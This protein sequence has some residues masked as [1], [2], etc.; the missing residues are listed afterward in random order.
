M[1]SSHRFTRATSLR[2][3]LEASERALARRPRMRCRLGAYGRPSH[4]RAGRHWG[5]IRC[6]KARRGPTNRHR[7]VLRPRPALD[8]VADAPRLWDYS[9]TPGE[10]LR[11]SARIDCDV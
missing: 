6:P 1:S 8:C 10:G 2:E 4:I 5:L 9:R 7:L 3:F 11:G